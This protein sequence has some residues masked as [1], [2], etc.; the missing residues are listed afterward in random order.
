MSG[1]PLLGPLASPSDERERLLCLFV[2]EATTR[3]AM[4]MA[5]EVDF[6]DF[7]YTGSEVVYPYGPDQYQRSERVK[8]DLPTV[9]SNDL[10]TILR[11]IWIEE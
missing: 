5:G 9:N 10:G 4:F 8:G 3:T 2:S 7:P 11:Q 6:L 1:I